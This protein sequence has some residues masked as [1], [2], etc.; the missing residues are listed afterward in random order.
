MVKTTDKLI[1]T[2]ILLYA[3]TCYKVFKIRQ[4][5]Y[6]FGKIFWFPRRCKSHTL[7]LLCS[8]SLF[9]AVLVF[10]CCINITFFQRIGDMLPKVPARWRRSTSDGVRTLLP[11]PS[12]WLD[13]CV[14]R[15]RL[16]PCS[17]CHFCKSH[18]LRTITLLGY[19]PYLWTRFSDLLNSQYFAMQVNFLNSFCSCSWLF[20]TWA[21]FSK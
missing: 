8:L 10:C 14:V 21:F 16:M 15:G 3:E 19:S 17:P 13:N 4:W 2:S 6:L 12:A 20:T 9:K 5:K 11:Q 1:C 18:S 7:P